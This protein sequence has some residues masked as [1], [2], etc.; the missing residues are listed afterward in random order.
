MKHW[1]FPA[2]LLVSA[3]GGGSE[4]T[5]SIASL[6]PAKSDSAGVVILRHEGDPFGRAPKLTLDSVALAVIKG[7]ADDAAADI[8]TIAPLLF[9]ADGRLVGRDQQR[10]VVVVFGADGS[11]RKEVGRPG[12]GPG[13]FGAIDNIVPAGGDTLLIQDFRNLRTTVFDPVSGLGAEYPQ[14]K[15]MADGGNV[16]IGA[17]GGKLLFYGLNINSGADVLAGTPAGIKGVL[18]DPKADASRRAFTT[19]PAEKP[20]KAPRVIKGSG[21]MMRGGMAI[22]MKTFES[23][24]TAFAWGG[25]F[26]VVDPNQFRLEFRDTSGTLQQVLVVAQARTAVTEQLMNDNATEMI[27]K[28]TGASSGNTITIGV[29]ATRAMGSGGAVPDTAAIRKEMVANEHA[30]SLPLFD[31]TQVSPNGTLWVVDYPF[32]GAEGWAAT[33]FAKDGRILGRIVEAKGQAPLAFGDDRVVFRTEDDLGIGTFTV[34]K[35]NFPK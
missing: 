24:P 1:H 18:F 4:A 21:G 25:R 31:R 17:T 29:G 6:E 9:L 28:I 34:R 27:A 10:Q 30:D 3:C 32:P 23:F 5:T 12:A 7:S 8:S 26:V 16:L 35:V 22:R 20:P 15:A 33:A 2:L 19:G 11:S 13:E 14:A